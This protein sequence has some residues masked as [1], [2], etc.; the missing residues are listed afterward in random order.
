M[1]A[2]SH[3]GGLRREHADGLRSQPC[4][5]HECEL[6]SAKPPARPDRGQR[7][8]TNF[9]SAAFWL[10]AAQLYTTASYPAHD[11]TGIRLL[12]NNLTGWNFAGQN[13]TGADFYYATLNGA[14]LSQANLANAYV[15]FA[16]LTDADLPSQP[17]K[18]GLLRGHA[19]GPNLTGADA[20]GAFRFDSEGPI[21]TNFIHPDG[22]VGGLFLNVGETLVVRDH[23]GSP[24][25]A[26]DNPPI[27]I[28]VDEFFTVDADGSLRMLFEADAWDSTISFAAGIPVTLAARW[29]STS[30]TG[31]ASPAKSAGRSTSSIGPASLRLALQR[32]EPVRLGSVQPIHHWRSH[33]RSYS[34]ALSTLALAAAS[35]LGLVGCASRRQ[36]HSSD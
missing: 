33:A 2:E 35:V 36:R 32:L 16:T 30:P 26:G 4:Q 25:P 20:R 9:G 28:H 23:D 14:N 15:D 3:E 27:P 21:V 1:P 18:Y 24:I 11:L 8:P 5:S 7:P 13:L 12:A 10:T 34:R 19:D 17:R 6:P 29:N 22:H 31:R